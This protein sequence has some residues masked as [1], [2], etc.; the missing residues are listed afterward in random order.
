MAV[1]RAAVDGDG[2]DAAESVGCEG[3]SWWRAANMK[4]ELPPSVVDSRRWQ[5][6]RSG[7]CMVWMRGL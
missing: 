4:V 2:A 7:K 5:A 6:L 1:A 3:Q